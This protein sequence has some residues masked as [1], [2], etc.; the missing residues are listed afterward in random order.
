MQGGQEENL[1][2]QYYRNSDWVAVNG[3]FIHSNNGDIAV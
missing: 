2:E 3:G 1:D